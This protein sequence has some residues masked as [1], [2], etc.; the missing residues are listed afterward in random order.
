LPP[1]VDAGVPLKSWPVG[2]APKICTGSPG[3]T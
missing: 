2:S 1:R 3:S